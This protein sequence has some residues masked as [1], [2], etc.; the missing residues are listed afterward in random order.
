MT[1]PMDVKRLFQEIENSREDMIELLSGLIER[2]AISPESGGD[3]E[4]VKAAFIA[5]WL[6]KNGFPAPEHYDAADPGAKGGI[7]PNL[8]VRIPGETRRRLWLVTHMDVVPEGDPAPWSR[9]PFRACRCGGRIYGRGSTDNG[10]E[11]AASMLAARAFLRTGLKPQPEVCLCLVS[12]EETGSE[13]GIRYLL[14]SGLFEQND[15]VITP[16]GGSP[17]GDFMEVA[18]KHILWL[19]FSLEGKQ[20]H[21][22]LPG[23]GLN[24]CRAA[25]ILSVRLDEALHRVFPEEDDLF[26]PPVSTFEPTMRAANVSNVN[27][28]PGFEEICFDC[29]LLPST[30]PDEVLKTVREVARNVADETGVTWDLRL[31][32]DTRSPAPTPTDSD[33][34]RLLSSSIENVLGVTA[35]AGG[36]GGGTCAA[37]FRREGI[38]AV[39]WSRQDPL[40]HMPDEYAVEEYMMDEARVFAAMMCGADDIL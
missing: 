32:Q 27:T 22:S 15:L 30:D 3:G 14:R 18:E 35:R 25:N 4:A 5:D 40:D 12:D 11:M 36:V 7:R 16:D 2:P 38:P 24:A 10:Q 29:R 28:V 1:D 6:R 9:D 21:A 13:K 37:W 31:L 19:S 33:V 17:E 8:V 23:L 20:T 34:V 39:V 26:R